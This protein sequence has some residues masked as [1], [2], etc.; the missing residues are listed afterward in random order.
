MWILFISERKDK[1]MDIMCLCEWIE[2]PFEVTRKIV[3]LENELISMDIKEVMKMS[4]NAAQWELMLKIINDR[5]GED[6]FGF[7]MLTCQMIGAI[8]AYDDYK[9]R[10]IS[11]RIYID[12]M[13]FFSRFM[14]AFYREHGFYKYIWG[15]W[16][17][18]QIG[19]HEFR[20]GELEYEMA[21]KD[22]LKIVEI[23]IPADANMAREHLRISY[24]MAVEFL[25]KYFPGF[26]YKKMTCSSWLLSPDLSVLLGE[27]S[28]IVRFQRQFVIE[29]IDEESKGFMDWVY[30]SQDIPYKELPEDTRL[31][32]KLKPHLL[33]G[34]KVGWA[35]GTLI[36]DPFMQNRSMK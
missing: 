15:W 34:G 18:R 33:C 5:I 2:M 1:Q 12:T 14:E 8:M 23:H 27:Q 17:A 13:K 20:I 11:D 25:E 30:G 26:H 28:R 36:Q 24:L 29:H 4:K 6:E 9:H 7:S 3:E 35:T 21:T 19:L 10:G 31:Q 22:G 16:A 32:R